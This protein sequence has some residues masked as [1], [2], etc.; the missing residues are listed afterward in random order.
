MELARA[1]AREAADGGWE[2][3][4]PRFMERAMAGFPDAGFDELD[5]AISRAKAE[6]EMDEWETEYLMS[7]GANP[8]PLLVLENVCRVMA[9]DPDLRGRFR[10][11][12]FNH[13]IEAERGGKWEN[14][15]EE[16]VL[17]AVRHIS[18]RHGEFAKVSKEM[19]VDA[20]RVT[21]RANRVNPPVDFLKALT[22][23]G[24][25]RVDRWLHVTYGTPDDALHASMGSNWLKGL[26]RRAIHPGFQF[27]EVLVLEGKQGF[28]KSTSLRVLG[29][30]WHV[31]STLSTDD[32][33]FYMLLARNVIVEF[34][35]GDILGHTS[36]KKLKAVI[37]KVEDSYRPPY[38]RGMMTFRRGCV[39]AMTTNDTQYQK[40][41]T[42]GRR[43]LPVVLTR[44]ADID[45][46]KANRDQL[47]AEAVYRTEVLGETSHVYDPG[48]ADLQGQKV[49]EDEIEEPIAKWYD[50]LPDARR[51]AGVTAL[52]VWNEAINERTN[53]KD[54]PRDMRWRIPKVL[55]LSFK[56]ER[57]SVKKDKRSSWRWFPS[58]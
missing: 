56:M 21:A 33:D 40:D 10:L 17:K 50:A 47:L 15:Q 58:S 52:E 45:W 27:D 2:G 57:R 28:R 55:K 14:L 36:S 18:V 43:W 41:E 42:G 11:N 35:E 24:V 1:A 6:A 3:A 13:M 44:P 8:K 22:W 23:D 26:A 39:F 38:E 16:D 7:D 12:D 37:T 29:Q 9:R 48:L 53:D 20:I 4:T 19:T 49:E 5:T 25:P 31:E 32:K 34:S 54:L 46:L 51:E 30:P